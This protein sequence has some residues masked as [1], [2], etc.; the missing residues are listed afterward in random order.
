MV[1]SSLILI[2][3]MFLVY[4]K[5]LLKNIGILAVSIGGI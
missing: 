4:P 5:G 3:N 2:E 1:K